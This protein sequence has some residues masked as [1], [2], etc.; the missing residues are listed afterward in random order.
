[1]ANLQDSKND[2]TFDVI[3]IGS[4]ISGGWAAKELTEKGLKV[5]MLER[6]PNHDHIKDY[7]S[8]SKD[9]WQFEHA[10]KTTAQQKKDYSV[11]HRGWAASES[12]M[13]AWANETGKL[14]GAPILVI[15]LKARELPPEEPHRGIIARYRL[16]PSFEELFRVAQA[17][18][19]NPKDPLAPFQYILINDEIAARDAAGVEGVIAHEL[20]HLWIKSQGFATAQFVPGKAACLSVVSGDMVQH[21]VIRHEMDRRRIHWRPA[22]IRETEPALR[23][24]EK[25]VGRPQ[26]KVP[27]CQKLAQI[28]LW[29]DVELGLT[30]K[31]WPMRDRFLELLAK[32]FPE[33]VRIAEPLA[34]GSR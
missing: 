12:V 2:R 1:M 4:G 14:A 31:D 22:W 21:A 9:P 30:V 18:S 33:A 34:D 8:A 3:V 10:G 15:R 6:G 17:L 11:I 27:V 25:D 24:L 20:G 5:L 26:D 23:Q 16:T 13:D 32:R 28:L 29:V 7:K 19:L